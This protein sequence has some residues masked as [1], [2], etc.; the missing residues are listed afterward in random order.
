MTAA[1]GSAASL[2]AP[3]SSPKGIFYTLLGDIQREDKHSALIKRYRRTF[4]GL[5][6][7]WLAGGTITTIQHGEIMAKL[8]PGSWRIWR[9][10]VYVI[11]RAPLEAAGRLTIVPPALRASHG[12]EYQVKD[13]M[14]HEFDV[15]EIAPAT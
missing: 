3:S 11:P 6:T 9:P 15:I 5:A 2:I 12:V 10:V 7:D 13:L 1:L 4:R 8:A 14:P